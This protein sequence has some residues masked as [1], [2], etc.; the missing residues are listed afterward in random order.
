MH[1]FITNTEDDLQQISGFLAQ[2]DILSV[3]NKV[4]KLL[5]MFRQLQINSLID[6]MVMIEQYA[7]LKLPEDDVKILAGHFY[8]EATKIVTKLSSEFKK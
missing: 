2:N 6:E 5:P 7:E 8:Q 4:H 3:S 1:S